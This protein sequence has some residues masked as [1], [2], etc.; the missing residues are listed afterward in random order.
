MGYARGLTAWNLAPLDLPAA[1]AL[2][3]TPVVLEGRD[4]GW[5]QEIGRQISRTTDAAERAKL[6]KDRDA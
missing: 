2:M 5:L 3:P 6:E 1:L 4:A